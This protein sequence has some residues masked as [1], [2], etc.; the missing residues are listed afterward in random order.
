MSDSNQSEPIIDVDELLAKVRRLERWEQEALFVMSEWNKVA[1]LL[2]D[3]YVRLG[4][5]RWRS[6]ARYIQE[7]S[8]PEVVFNQAGEPVRYINESE[9]NHAGEWD[10]QNVD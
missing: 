2:P 1:D 4:E 7:T 9:F 8:K 10:G 6:V 5:Y 3:G